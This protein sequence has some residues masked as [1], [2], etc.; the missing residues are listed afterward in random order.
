M[1]VDAPIA[2]ISASYSD[3]DRA[4]DDFEAVWRVRHEGDFHH[5]AIALL[6][7]DGAHG[8][9]VERT[10]NTAKHLEWGGALLGAP[11]FVLAPETGTELLAAVGLSGAGAIACHVR[12]NASPVEL[13]TSARVLR[14]GACSLVLVVVNRRGEE[15]TQLLTQA[16][17]TSSVDLVWGDLE[18][19]LSRDFATPMSGP[20]LVAV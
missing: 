5:T 6:A 20:V 19:E 9:H 11:L 3:R 4:V 14:S 2:L 10:N 8:L 7:S 1:K 12:L 13:A 17:R 15:V 16:D 18:E